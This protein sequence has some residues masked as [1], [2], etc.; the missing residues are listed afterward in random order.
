VGRI[1]LAALAGVLMVTSFR[2]IG[3]AT[4]RS[5]LTS[6]R[7]DALTFVVT[8]V[9]TVAFDL[10]D[11]VQIG[12]LIAAFFALRAVARG[13]TVH[14]EPLPGVAHEGDERIALF[15]LDGAMFFGASD[16]ILGEVTAITHAPPDS[17]PETLH[18]PVEVV[19]LRLSHLQL[20]DAT[21]ARALAD[22][23]LELERRGVTV[24]VKGIQPQHGKLLEAVGLNQVLRHEN[25]QFAELPEAIE[26]ARSHVLR[27]AR[28]RDLGRDGHRTAPA[29]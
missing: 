7:P 4:I 18:E 8:A 28:D 15:R 23:V 22:L 2:M 25:H 13:T 3:A 10:I 20:V 26:H 14:R 11:A 17:L 19:I 12:L 27:A 1:P 6:T 21:G 9:I 24:L 29:R 5:V 16:R